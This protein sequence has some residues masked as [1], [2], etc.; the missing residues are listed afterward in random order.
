[1][2]VWSKSIRVDNITV[3]IHWQCDSLLCVFVSVS[4]INFVLVNTIGMPVNTVHDGYPM[5]SFV[6]NEMSLFFN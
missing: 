6:P 4:E 1:M 2:T 3:R 5:S